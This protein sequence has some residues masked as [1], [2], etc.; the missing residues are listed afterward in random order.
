MPGARLS[1]IANRAG[2]RRQQPKPTAAQLLQRR[3][4]PRPTAS[5]LR[6]RYK[7]IKANRAKR[8]PLGRVKTLLGGSIRKM[9][10]VR[11]KARKVKPRKPRKKR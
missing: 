4:R 9:K 7:V 8:T 3:Q 5:D 6:Q 11:R 2:R 1:A 10:P